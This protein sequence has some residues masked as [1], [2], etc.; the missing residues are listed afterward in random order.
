M[1]NLIKYG[2]YFTPGKFVYFVTH[3]GKS[4]GFIRKAIVL[5]YCV[6][7]AE[8]P[9]AV[10]AIL[11]GALGYLILPVDVVPDAIAALGWLDDVAVLTM[12]TKVAEK[13]IKPI[14]LEM[15]KKRMPF[16]KDV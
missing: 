11:V 3:V 8:T 10:K 7:D 1:M 12:A 14:H 15:A 9:A 16:G 5:Y 13:Y 4:L 6:R 2:K